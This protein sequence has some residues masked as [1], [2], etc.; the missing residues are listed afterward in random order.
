MLISNNFFFFFNEQRVF[1]YKVC[2]CII[3]LTFFE[4]KK[5]D[6]IKKT[7]D[8]AKDKCDRHLFDIFYDNSYI[9]CCKICL[10]FAAKSDPCLYNDC[11]H[12]CPNEAADPSSVNCIDLFAHGFEGFCVGCLNFVSC[13][14]IK[15]L[16]TV[17]L[18]WNP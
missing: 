9:V 6:L 15:N 4:V 16:H 11:S 5:F 12:V 13:F 3:D 2:S 14:L 1:E 7:V 8:F 17:K 10:G 18:K